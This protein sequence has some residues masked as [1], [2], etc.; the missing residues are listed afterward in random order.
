VHIILKS[1]NYCFLET[2]LNGNEFIKEMVEAV[3]ARV[4]EKKRNNSSD[5]DN[6]L[7]WNS[8]MEHPQTY[9]FDL[10]DREEDIRNRNRGGPESRIGHDFSKAPSRHA[11]A[12]RFK[13]GST[14]DPTPTQGNFLVSERL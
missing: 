1:E 7:G 9:I 14:R 12:N 5:A 6:H 11:K 10:E 3:N 8:S 4:I 2:K 13:R